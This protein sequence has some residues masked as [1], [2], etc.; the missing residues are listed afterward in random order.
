MVDESTTQERILIVEDEQ[1]ARS[2]GYE[3]LL[4]KVG[5]PTAGRRQ[6]RRSPRK[7]CRVPARAD[8]RGCRI[9]GHG[10][11]RAITS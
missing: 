3:A 5:I 1:N 7:I 10:W 4:R 6:R 9:A 8:N 11:P 2:T